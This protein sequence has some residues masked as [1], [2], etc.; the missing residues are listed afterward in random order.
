MARKKKC[1]SCFEEVATHFILENSFYYGEMPICCNC[2]E[3]CI[4]EGWHEKDAELEAS[5]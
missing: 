5:L 1:Q 2:H 4:K 3:Q